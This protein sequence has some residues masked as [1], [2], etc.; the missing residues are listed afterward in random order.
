LPS[1]V[2]LSGAVGGVVVVPVVLVR[3]GA[4]VPAP[5]VPPPGAPIPG[6]GGRIPVEPAA[7]MLPVPLGSA[8][9][10]CRFGVVALEVPP[11]LPAGAYWAPALPALSSAAMRARLR[12]CGAFIFV[13]VEL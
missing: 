4:V 2:V 11:V 8:L 5:D 3:V 12:G 13:R 6:G 10:V 7:L 1:L 9:A